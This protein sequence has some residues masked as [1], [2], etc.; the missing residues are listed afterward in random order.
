MRP[1]TEQ[2]KDNPNNNPNNNQTDAAL[3]FRLTKQQIA[4]LFF[5]AIDRF[6]SMAIL[7]RNGRGAF[8]IRND[9][10]QIIFDCLG[11]TL[12]QKKFKI[13]MQEIMQSDSNFCLALSDYVFRVCILNRITTLNIC[14]KLTAMAI[15][16]HKR[17]SSCDAKFL[18]L[19]P[20]E[21]VILH[22]KVDKNHWF[23]QSV[24]STSGSLALSNLN[25]SAS[26]TKMLEND[27]GTTEINY[28]LFLNSSDASN[29]SPERRSCKGNG[30]VSNLTS[31]PGPNC[32]LVQENY[33]IID[34]KGSLVSSY[35]QP[36]NL[37]R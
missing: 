14:P 8:L 17:E 6:D 22:H 16:A 21:V 19:D 18:D 26:R 36:T 27:E 11:K 37:A 9:G 24:D 33:L 2:P 5:G 7:Q 1:A 32:G 23:C 30:Q 3:T 10:N 13:T 12:E 35:V 25:I 15:F 28:P 31:N 34:F 4:A 20:G 29:N